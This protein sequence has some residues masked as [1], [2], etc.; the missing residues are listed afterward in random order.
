MGPPSSEWGY[1]KEQG[2]NWEEPRVGGKTER[3]EGER[4]DDIGEVTTTPD[5]NARGPTG[6]R[7]S[8]QKGRSG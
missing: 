6:G 8:K 3:E 1:G 7:N 4:M 2:K 5:V